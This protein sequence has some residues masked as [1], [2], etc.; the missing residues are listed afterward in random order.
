[1][2]LLVFLWSVEALAILSIGVLVL[3]AHLFPA[4]ARKTDWQITRCL[5]PR[6][7]VR[8]LATG[9]YFLDPGII[10]RI[11]GLI[12]I[13]SSVLILLGWRYRGPGIAPAA[14]TGAIQ[15]SLMGLLDWVAL[16]GDLSYGNR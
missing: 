3:T 13:S 1:M 4:A 12:I 6:S 10:R 14:A 2:P 5:L 8:P 16:H 9:F 11:I 7:S 15:A